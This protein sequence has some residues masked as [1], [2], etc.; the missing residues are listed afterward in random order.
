MSQKEIHT[1]Q[2]LVVGSKKNRDKDVKKA[3]LKTKS[4]K[5]PWRLEVWVG[6]TKMLGY[7]Y[8]RSV[9]DTWFVEGDKKKFEEQLKKD[10]SKKFLHES[11]FEIRAVQVD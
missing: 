11:G 2:T 5:T 7:E 9:S 3:S 1:G 8:E 10:R 6:T 4:E